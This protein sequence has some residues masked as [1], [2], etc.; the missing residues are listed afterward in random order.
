MRLA[1][2]FGLS[3]I[4][5]TVVKNATPNAKSCSCYI[6]SALFKDLLLLHDEENPQNPCYTQLGKIIEIHMT[7]IDIA[8]TIYRSY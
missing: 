6:C 4:E 7:H 5:I 1:N 8:N 3:C 2:Y